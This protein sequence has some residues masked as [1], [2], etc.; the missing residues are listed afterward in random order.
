MD[1]QWDAPDAQLPGL[2]LD[3]M[4]P[5]AAADST[6]TVTGLGTVWH[7]FTGEISGVACSGRHPARHRCSAYQAGR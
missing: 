3:Q 2:E 7:S 6:Q 4:V 1:H 5:A